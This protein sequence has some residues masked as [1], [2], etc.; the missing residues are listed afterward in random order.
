[1]AASRQKFE[2]RKNEYEAIEDE[3]EE[4]NQEI[5]KAKHQLNE[6]TLL[7]QQLEGQI[8]VLNEQI[9]TARTNDEHYSNRVSIIQMCIR[10][11]CERIGIDGSLTY[12][13]QGGEK[14]KED[15]AMPTH[16]EAI[17]YVIDALTDE[18]TGVVKNLAEIGAVGHRVVHGCLLY[19]SRCV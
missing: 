12:Q 18:T 2:E 19:T 8:N 7:K 1:M 11:S 3:I 17:S 6:T 9:N 14:V 16:K 5:E 13:P 10:D 15:K 4:I